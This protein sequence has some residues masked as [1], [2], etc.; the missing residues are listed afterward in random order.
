[1]INNKNKKEIKVFKIRNFISGFSIVEIIVYLAIFT[2]ISILVINSFI[3]I[4]SSFNTTN[5]NRK[6]LESGSIIME[7]VS[8]EIRQAKSIDIANSSLNTSPGVLQLNSVNSEGDTKIIK[9]IVEGQN[10][11]LYQNGDLTGNLLSQ[12]ISM[13][14]LIFGRIATTNG[15][16]V[17]IEMALQFSDGSN[18]KTENFYNTI[19]LRGGY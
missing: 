5:T 2:S 11:N 15:E 14:S 19:I 3:I 9:L 1:M 13:D 4:L 6:L 8:R 7:R 10:F 12:N 16:A 17:K 18:P